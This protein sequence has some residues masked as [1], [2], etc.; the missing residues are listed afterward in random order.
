MLYKRLLSAAIGVPLVLIPLWYG[1]WVFFMLVL[2]IMGVISYELNRVFR[3]MS[4]KTSLPMMLAGLLALSLSAYWGGGAG[5]G[6]A[7]L[8]VVAVLLVAGVFL[9]PSLKPGDLAATVSGMLYVSLF[10]YV[11]LLRNLDGGFA[12]TMTLLAGIWLSDT[13]AYFF[14]KNFGKKK[15][16]KQLSPGKTVEGALAGLA[17]GVAGTLLIYM[18]SPVVSLPKAVA[19][20]VLLSVAGLLGDLLESS[21]KR[22]AGIKDAGMILPGH[23]GLLDRF[24]GMLI[25]APAL[26]YFIYYL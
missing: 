25:A 18:Y 23:G 9:Y 3:E 8:P 22:T 26:Y 13:A 14:G 11:Y 10:L 4:L 2:L 5:L 7:V 15:L 20:G 19:I 21:L 12:L 1:G 17:G 16:A 24:D 6:S